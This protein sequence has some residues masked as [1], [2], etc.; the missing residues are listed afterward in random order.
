MLDVLIV[1]GGP[2]ALTLATLLAHPDARSPQTG[3]DILDGIQLSQNKSKSSRSK[4]KRKPPIG[5]IAEEEAPPDPVPSPPLHFRVVDSY[6]EWATLWKSQFS[7]LNIP[8]LRSHTLVHTDP[9]NK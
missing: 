9:L 1:G 2:H 3:T 8:H 6:G 7:A 5:V 4:S